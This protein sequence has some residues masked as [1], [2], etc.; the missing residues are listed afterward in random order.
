MYSV[1]RLEK[2]TEL[3]RVEINGNLI[4]AVGKQTASRVYAVVDA[5]G[6][7]IKNADGQFEIYT[8]KATAQQVA[9]NEKEKK[10]KRIAWE[11]SISQRHPIICHWPRHLW[12]LIA[13]LNG[14]LP[15]APK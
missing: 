5:T 3:K 12:A 13:R 11:K 6:N 15:L 10:M 1:Q 9:K 14:W 8:R 2:G 7:V 4:K